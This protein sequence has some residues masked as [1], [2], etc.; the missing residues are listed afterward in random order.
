MKNLFVLLGFVFMFT[1]VQAQELAF[2][3]TKNNTFDSSAKVDILVSGIYKD[4]LFWV[5][6]I[7]MG[8]REGNTFTSYGSFT[9]NKKESYLRKGAR[10]IGTLEVGPRKTGTL[11]IDKL[12]GRSF[13]RPKSVSLKFKG[14]APR[15]R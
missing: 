4:S 6:D 10:G 7:R 13:T 9:V 1:N 5:V 14:N 12:G 15:L 11:K 8:G 2:A 3:D